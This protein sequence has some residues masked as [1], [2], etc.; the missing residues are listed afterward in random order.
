MFNRLGKR[1]RSGR[2]AVSFSSDDKVIIITV[3]V[4]SLLVLQSI[5]VPSAWAK[6]SNAENSS[7]LSLEK[8]HDRYHERRKS[9][10]AIQLDLFVC[11]FVY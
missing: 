5:T 2:S 7:S 4:V 6:I 3:T 10:T 9:N 1:I 11:M 8:L